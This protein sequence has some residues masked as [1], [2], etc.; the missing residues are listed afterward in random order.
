VQ[1]LLAAVTLRHLVGL[2][3]HLC[4]GSHDFNLHARSWKTNIFQ[5]F[6][7]GMI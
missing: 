4:Q 3:H 2:A 5:R 7:R 1:H 6:I